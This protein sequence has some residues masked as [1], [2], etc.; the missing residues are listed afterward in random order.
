MSDIDPHHRLL[1]LSVVGALL[2]TVV[3]LVLGYV[4]YRAWRFP[5]RCLLRHPPRC[6]R[7]TRL[8]T[9]R[10]SPSLGVARF[11][12]TLA[13]V[14]ASVVAVTALVG[15]TVRHAA[16]LR[17]V[18]GHVVVLGLSDNST[19]F[20][21]ALL[22]QGLPVVVVEVDGEH[23]GLQAIKGVG[24]MVVVGDASR[25]QPQRQARVDRSLR[26]VVSTGDDGRNL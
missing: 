21:H 16:R 1:R 24:A 19:E 15:Q 2:L 14:M 9:C 22:E 17:R 26:V 8:A 6:S 20:A 11:T 7:S 5:A 4:G 10:P 3:S 23:P 13:L 18:K 12:A 25:E